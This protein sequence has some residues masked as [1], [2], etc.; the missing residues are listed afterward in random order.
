MTNTELIVR[1]DVIQDPRPWER[2]SPHGCA[3]IEGTRGR[4]VKFWVEP[5]VQPFG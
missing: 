5:G 1:R 2:R 3:R 4:H